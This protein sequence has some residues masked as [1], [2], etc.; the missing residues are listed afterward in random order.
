MPSSIEQSERFEM[1]PAEAKEAIRSFDYDNA[2][3]SVHMKHKL[4]IDQAAALEREVTEVVFGD[5]KP[6]DLIPNI[7]RELRV[8]AAMAKDIAF[9]VNDALLKPIQE[10]MKKVKPQE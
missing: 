2:L 9:D 5:S 3:R 1:L 10:L 4:H 7:E 8:D 6:Y